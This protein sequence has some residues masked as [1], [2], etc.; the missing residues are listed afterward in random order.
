MHFCSCKK[1]RYGVQYGIDFLA[2]F[3]QEGRLSM[4]DKKYEV[5][6]DFR[7]MALVTAGNP[8]DFNTMTIG[9]GGLG[10]IW[11]KPVC[12]VYVRKSRYTYEYLEKNE[13]FTVSFFDSDREALIY[14]GSHSGR[15]GDKVKASGL[16]PMSVEHGVA[17]REASAT[18]TCKKL[19]KQ[20]MDAEA[21]PQD[22][23]D[24]FYSGED[25]GNMHYMFI[26]E[27]VHAEE[28]RK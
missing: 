27:V 25:E 19:Y 28:G 4:Y 3:Q 21:I 17:F 12:T 15:D 9:W 2:H 26:G 24:R 20:L 13:Y 22:I 5:F 18:L 23:R 14:L 6:N 1:S 8:R 11:G 7:K 10:T 16:T